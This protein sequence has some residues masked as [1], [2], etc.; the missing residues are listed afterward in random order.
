MLRGDNWSF[1]HIPKCGGTALRY[2]L[3]GIEYGEFMP[4]GSGC[5][6]R[7]ALHRI[8]H[9][10]PSG[11]VFTVVRHPAAWLRSYWLDQSPQRIGVNRFLHQF[12]STDLDEFVMNVC[13]GRP[14][15]V[16]MLYKAYM[17]Y[18]AIK[19]FRLE[20]GL[21]H[22][23]RWLGV[24]PRKIL[25]VNSSPHGPQLSRRSIALVAH[26]ERSVL[27]QFGYTS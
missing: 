16:A 14:G 19:V 25:T 27:D 23:L 22:V 20:D 4:L 12:W 6:V 10:R 17:R 3:D 7:S 11:R 26:T 24:E 13:T 1:I 21:D 18:R 8:P 9:K 2:H 5:A 15:Y